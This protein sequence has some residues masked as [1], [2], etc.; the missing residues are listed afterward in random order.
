VLC[1]ANKSVRLFRHVV[2][3]L[4]QGLQPDWDEIARVG[5][6]MRTTA[7][8]GNGKFG[9]ADRAC[10]AQ[11]ADF[12]G[13]FRAEMLAVWLVRGFTLDLVEHIAQAQNPK[14]ARLGP[15]QRR[16]LGIGNATG[17]GMAPFL[18]NH[19]VLLNNW[20]TARET[21]L[22]R[23]RAIPR[24][25]A[26]TRRQVQALV[27]RVRAHLAEWQVADA[28]HMGRI[29]QLRADWEDLA[30]FARRGVLRGPHPWDGLMR[31]AQRLS[32][33]A[34]ELLVSVLI[35]PH[36]ALVDDLCAQMACD[37][38]PCLQPRQRLATLRA[39]LRAHYDWAL[40]L[41]FDDPQATHQFWYVSEDK[42]EP[43]L[44]Q[45]A[46]EPGADKEMPL[47]VAR[48]A[49]ALWAALAEAAP[50]QSVAELAMRRPDLRGV[51]ARVQ[52]APAHPYAEIRDNLIGSACL[53]I[54]ML[55]CKL[56]FFGAS[57]FDPKSDRW[58]RVT[59]FQGAPGFDEVRRPDA[60]DWA[61][62][63]LGRGG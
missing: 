48:Q 33:D 11:R 19:P 51:I 10:L 47:D 6:L 1:R 57:K 12:S 16:H 34:Q 63:A 46:I 20:I 60:D 55:R 18:V 7:V 59:L 31:Y 17:L 36:G 35:E 56:S 30:D 41:D 8:Y 58:T 13:P 4:A 14:A 24:A 53:P 26:A 40:R 37:A 15:A 54:D 50:E 45:R 38:E 29:R 44:G 32:V 3:Q 27:A 9:I 52:A 62:P 5:Y 2:Q 28:G 22:A 49:Q 25:D 23:V 39:Q 42:L 43:R 61:F 21:A